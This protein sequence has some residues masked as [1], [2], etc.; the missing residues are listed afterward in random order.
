MKKRPLS[1]HIVGVFLFACASVQAGDYTWVSGSAAN[2]NGASAWSPNTPIPGASDNVVGNSGTGTLQVNGGT[3]TISNFAITTG[4]WDIRSAASTT[5]TLDVTNSFTKGGSGTSLLFNSTGTLNITAGNLSVTGGTLEVGASNNVLNSVTVSGVTTV[6][7]GTALN[8]NVVSPANLGA[9]TANGT[10]RLANSTAT[11][12]RS[13]SVSSLAGSGTVTGN[14]AAG[15]G[16]TAA[17]SITGSSSTTF[18]GSIENGTGSTVSLAKSGVG[19]QVLSGASTYSGGTTISA[20]TLLVDNTTGS[21][22]GTGAVL[23]DSAGTLGGTGAVTLSAGNS[24]T[25]QGTVDVGNGASA[26]TFD[27]TT[28]GGG[29]LAFAN[30]A[31]L[32]LDIWTNSVSGADK[33]ATTGEVT[34]GTGVALTVSNA[35]GVAFAFGNSFDLFDWGTAPTG[36]TFDLSLPSLTGGLSWDTA[37]LYTTGEISVVPEPRTIALLTFV[38]MGALFLRRRSAKL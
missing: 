7:S 17:L 13:V 8:L 21:G 20:G 15:T 16:I 1:F 24:V 10:V 33:L 25:V 29:A 18:S 36:G 19:T 37:A 14:A 32:A 35:G 11:V 6:D 12:A 27:V 9:L 4:N 22:L 28:S 3:R 5:N 38:G 31:A 34:I 30:D 23:V 2:W 26:A